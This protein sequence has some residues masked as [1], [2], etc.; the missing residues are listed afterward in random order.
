M[1]TPANVP[2]LQATTTVQTVIDSAAKDAVMPFFS[3]G[4]NQTM[5]IDYVNR[6]QQQMNRFA[7]WQWQLS[8]VKRFITQ[9]GQT[10][11]WLGTA[12]S[13]PAGSVDTNLNITDLNQIK[14]GTVYDRTNYRELQRVVEQP[15]LVGL[16]YPDVS[17]RP[18]H[19]RMWRES[20][21]TPYI[22]NLYPAPDVQNLG[23]WPPRPEPAY[24]T[25]VA[26]GA[27]SARIYYIFITFMDAQGHESSGSAY[28][29]KIY[30]PASKLL[31][32]WS[33]T[34]AIPASADG[35]AYSQ[36]R[37]YASTTSMAE[38]VQ[39]SGTAINIGTNFTESVGGLDTTG[40]SVPTAN[41]I[42]PINGYIIEFRY[43]KQR[44]TIAATTDVLSV[45]DIYIDIL[46]A[47]VN[48]FVAN[49]MVE[50]DSRYSEL[51]EEWKSRY[52]AGLTEIIKDFN[53]FPKGND[54]I[55][56][57]RAARNNWTWTTL[58]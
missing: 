13:N 54:F 38:T 29:T 21:D 14:E 44:V 57:D 24:C 30:V 53:L 55:G 47:G 19:P 37:I 45:P 35:T 17:S 7:R 1:T 32:V 15:T 58:Y 22:M 34:I 16:S 42:E 23:G 52:R 43:W 51:R 20:P 3:N 50:T 4:G 25:S 18:S 8:P 39:N 48:E 5:L 11:Y 27:L 9:L 31:K 10:D 2:F 56:P 36:W 26:G 41:N 49:Y 33:P 40:A 28:E 46:T 12:G 6:V